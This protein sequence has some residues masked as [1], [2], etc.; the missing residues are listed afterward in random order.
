MN[1][2]QLQLISATLYNYLILRRLVQ[3]IHQ[4]IIAF[5]VTPSKSVCEHINLTI[6]TA[7]DLKEFDNAKQFTDG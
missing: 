7:T 5:I 4:L 2:Y 6:D 3:R 1:F